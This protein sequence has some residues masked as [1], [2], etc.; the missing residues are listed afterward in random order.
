MPYADADVAIWSH[1]FT[2]SNP[3][4]TTPPPHP[5]SSLSSVFLILLQPFIHDFLQNVHNSRD[6]RS[7]NCQLCAKHFTARFFQTSYHRGSFSREQIYSFY[8]LYIVTLLICIWFSI[9]ISVLVFAYH[10]K[11]NRSLKQTF[12]HSLT[13][14]I[15]WHNIIH[16]HTYK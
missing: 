6:G 1:M 7:F 3:S 8:K 14:I 13:C 15:F 12:T 10:Y 4:V 11:V 2:P 16:N 5:P 9:D